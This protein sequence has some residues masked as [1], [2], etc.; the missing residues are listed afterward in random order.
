MGVRM[1]N[2]GSFENGSA[3]LSSGA[4]VLFGSG[5]KLVL[6]SIVLLACFTTC[7]GLTIA[8]SQYVTKHTDKISF[9]ATVSVIVAFSFF[10]S[11]LG[12]NQI[13]SLSVPV[14]IMVYPITIVLI[15]L[16]FLHRL[17]NGSQLVYQGAIALTSFVAI[18]EGLGMYGLNLSIFQTAV[19]SLPFAQLGL[20]WL[21]PAFVGGAFGYVLDL[22]KRKRQPLSKSEKVA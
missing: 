11:N 1:A 22:I 14:L 10:V 16:A 17:F 13:I 7:V 15:T 9:K 18:V 12:L 19:E 21:V 5:G 8:C 20:G 3:I 6:G 4:E 2:Y